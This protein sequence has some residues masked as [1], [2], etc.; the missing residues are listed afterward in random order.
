MRLSRIITM[1]FLLGGFV[2]LGFMV[3]RVGWSGV[4]DSFR[5][6][7]PWIV[8]YALLRVVPIVLHT[9]GW[10]ACF[11]GRH[12]PL[13]LWQLVLIRQAG[14]T[15]NQL[16]PT[17]DIGGEV[18]KVVLLESVLPREQAVAAVVIEKGSATLAKMLYLALGTLYI[19]QR[20]PLPGEL[21]ISLVL[22]IV[23]ISLGLLGFIAFQRYGLVSRLVQQCAR[24]PIARRRVQGLG[25]RLAR[26]DAQL[27][28]YYTSHPWRF[29]RSLVL[30][31]FG[32]AFDIVRT[33]ILLR[34]ILGQ[35][36][37][38]FAEAIMITVAVTALDQM[39]FFVPGGVGTFEGARFVVL[40]ALG[41]AH[42]YGLAFGIVARA[43][44]LAWSAV[45]MLAYACLDRL[46]PRSRTTP[47]ARVASPL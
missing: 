27:V 25:Q 39:F 13:S 10:A 7:G 33:Y 20:L 28:A 24:L 46:L 15:I 6:M 8:P 35:G 42:V 17:A 14:N 38:G 47:G 2:L 34:L 43:E 19:T 12:L 5:I 45:G 36:A 16:T 21:Y 4:L 9:T 1:V 11:P 40:S 22:T 44:Q 29:V 30:H 3:R 32:Y 37:P 18:S 41:V 26:L 31:V 23:L